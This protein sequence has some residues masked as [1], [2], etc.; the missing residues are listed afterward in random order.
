MAIEKGSSR[1]Q[2][3][4]TK[5]VTT[6][7]ADDSTAGKDKTEEH[8]EKLLFGDSAGFLG[9]LKKGYDATTT[10]L[11]LDQSSEPEETGIEGEED[12][13]LAGVADSDVS[14]PSIISAMDF[15]L[16]YFLFHSSDSRLIV[17]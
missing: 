14:I 4:I 1:R 16:V 15:F 9:S 12:E 10:D 6:D 7:K 2:K 11:V 3:T 5:D 17:S 13:D 8:L